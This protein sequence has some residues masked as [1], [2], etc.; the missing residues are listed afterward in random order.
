MFFPENCSL[1]VFFSIDFLERLKYEFEIGSIAARLLLVLFVLDQLSKPAQILSTG[2]SLLYSVVAM[3][4]K[5]YWKTRNKFD[6]M[7]K[8]VVKD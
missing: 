4:A 6:D 1:L 3:M 5:S 8:L 2:T 7:V